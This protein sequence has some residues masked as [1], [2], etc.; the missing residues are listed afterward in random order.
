MQFEAIRRFALGLLI[1]LAP[2]IAASQQII[3]VSPTGPIKTLAAARDAARAQRKAGATGIIAITIH[4]GT[5]FLPE[6]L[7]LTADDSNTTWE[8]A[9][10]E[11]PI[12]SGGR[13]INGWSK[14]SGDIWVAEARGP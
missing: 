11:H 14:G 7:L 8:A 1:L 3:E 12:I 13:V 10:G 2:A 9:H 6:T 5:Y 4:A